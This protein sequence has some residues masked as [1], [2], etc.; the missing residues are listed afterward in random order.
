MLKNL[1]N[2]LFKRTK[3]DYKQMLVTNLLTLTDL[4]SDQIEDMLEGEIIL[5]DCDIIELTDLDTFKE[6]ITA[7][8]WTKVNYADNMALFD[9]SCMM[10]IN[11]WNTTMMTRIPLEAVNERI[12]VLLGLSRPG[13]V[14][15]SSDRSSVE[16]I[17]KPVIQDEMCIFLKTIE[18]LDSIRSYGYAVQKVFIYNPNK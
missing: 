12:T 15:Y 9:Y 11:L 16:F 4:S 1:F 18:H 17:D 10:G 2:K 14:K 3:K 7:K 8:S 13:A 6:E 5:Q